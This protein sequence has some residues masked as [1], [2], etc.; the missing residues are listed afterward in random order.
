MLEPC[1]QGSPGTMQ[2]T[3]WQLAEQGKAGAVK[4]ISPSRQLTLSKICSAKS[5]VAAEDQL[6]CQEFEGSFGCQA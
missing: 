4:S 1:S 3:Y 6:A 2:T 5:S